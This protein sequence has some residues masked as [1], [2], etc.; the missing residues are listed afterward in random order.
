MQQTLARSDVSLELL[1]LRRKVIIRYSVVVVVF[2]VALQLDERLPSISVDDWHG[3]I[4]ELLLQ[5]GRRHVLKVTCI[6]HLVGMFPQLN[7]LRD[8]RR[9]QQ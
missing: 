2:L 5:Q 6:L 1:D 9:T 4:L 7:G 3:N 8:S